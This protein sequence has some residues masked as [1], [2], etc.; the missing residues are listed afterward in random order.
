MSYQFAIRLNGGPREGTRVF[1]HGEFPWP[2]PQ[3]LPDPAA[4]GEY[5]QTSCSGLEATD[6]ACD[7]LIRGAE[8]VWHSWYEEE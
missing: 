1:A 2:P 8:Y 6:P 4:W 7:H 3:R 5:Q